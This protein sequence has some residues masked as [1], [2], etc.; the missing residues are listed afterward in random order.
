ML[1]DEVFYQ[2]RIDELATTAS[3][4]IDPSLPTSTYL[5]SF[6]DTNVPTTPTPP[7]KIY[8]RSE[9]ALAY[10]IDIEKRYKNITSSI[11][12][13]GDRIQVEVSL[14]NTSTNTI[15]SIEYLDTIP[16]I[17][18]LPQDATYKTI[19]GLQSTDSPIEN[20]AG[21]DFDFGMR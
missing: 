2:R 3:I 11:L 4:N 17:F 15:S 18:S 12:H 16:K 8:V 19:L 14:K 7:P 9:Y 20:L 5:T 21:E 1:N 10:G 6:P 13:G